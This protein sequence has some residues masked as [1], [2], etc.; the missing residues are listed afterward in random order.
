MME[1]LYYYLIFSLTTSIY[2]WLVV[3]RPLKA[4]L[5]EEEVEHLYIKR[6]VLSSVVFMLFTALLSPIFFVV[7]L[8]DNVKNALIEGMYEGSL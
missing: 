2:L 7:V 8:S 3:F 4:K 6:P 5:L 1:L